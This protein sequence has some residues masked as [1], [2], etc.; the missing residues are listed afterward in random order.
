[1]HTRLIPAERWR[2]T[3]DDLSRTYD[4]SLVSIE[5]VGGDVGAEEQV[6]DQPLRGISSDRSGM[7][8]QIE[9]PGGI[10]FDHHVAHPQK[11]RIVET[12]EGALMAV[13]IEA[14]GGVHSLVRFLSPMR[15]ELFDPAVE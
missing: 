14:N 8:V 12:S 9:K 10:H 2:T 4:G 3:L 13:E 6:R 7:T 11:L 1:M 15:A 5:I